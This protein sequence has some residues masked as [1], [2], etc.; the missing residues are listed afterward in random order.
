MFFETSP[1]ERI[2]A[3]DE[4]RQRQG[5]EIQTVFTWSER[6]G[7]LD[8]TDAGVDEKFDV[9]DALPELIERCNA[10]FDEGAAILRRLDA[11]RTAFEKTH[12][13]RVFQVGNRSRNSRLGRPEALLFLGL[14]PLPGDTRES[15][16][17]RRS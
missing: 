6:E 13:D 11:A 7:G 8:V 12:P 10:V 9:L 3:N 16:A 2:T 4:D 17:S 5:F 1:A 15:K 14:P